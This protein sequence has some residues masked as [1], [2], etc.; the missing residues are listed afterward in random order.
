MPLPVVPT[1]LDPRALSSAPSR[2]RWYGRTTLARS[3]YPQT[4]PGPAGP[5]DLPA[6]SAALAVD[7]QAIADDRKHALADDARR[8]QV[9]GEDLVPHLDGVASVGAALVPNHQIGV[10]GQIVSNLALALV[11]PLRT[12]NRQ[13]RHRI[14]HCYRI[15]LYLDVVMPLAPHPDRCPA[16]RRAADR[17]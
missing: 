11:A 4:V 9:Q 12:D 10:L 7:D 13:S 15:P 5:P 1:P 16:P 8:Q 14:H 17:S 6:R 2:R 3:E